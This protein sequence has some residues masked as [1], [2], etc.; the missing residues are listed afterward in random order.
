M[1]GAP[2]RQTAGTNSPM[3]V[4]WQGHIVPE[5]WATV[6]QLEETIAIIHDLNVDCRLPFML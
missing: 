5:A 4:L 3:N 6:E 2:K 1:V